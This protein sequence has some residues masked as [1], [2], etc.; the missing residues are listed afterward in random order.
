[1]R[2]ERVRLLLFISLA[3]CHGLLYL[4]V[5][6][7]WQHYDE[8]THYEFSRLIAVLGRMPT[9]KEVDL[10]SRRAIG[11]S[12]IR[13]HFYNPG[14][15][16]PDFT[17][18]QPARLGYSQQVHP[19]FYYTLN[20]WAINLAPAASVE[21]QLYIARLVSVLLY[22]LTILTA[23]RIVTV[24]LPER[25]FFR[26]MLLLLLIFMPAFA[27][28][29]SAM[30]NDVLV[31]FGM[32]VLLLG[33][34]YLV[35][36][37]LRPLPLLLALLAL[38]VAFFAKRTSIVGIVPLAMALFWSLFR[39]PI[40]IR[41]WLSLLIIA[42]VAFGLLAFAPTTIKL[43][44]GLHATLGP[45]PWLAQLDRSYLRLD[46]ARFV[47]SL[48]DIPAGLAVYPNLMYRLFASF[49]M[50]YS[51]GHIR[52]GSGWE[53]AMI[54]VAGSCAAGLLIRGVRTYRQVGM[55]EQRWIWLLLVTALAATI[56]TSLRIHPLPI[57]GG[58][59]YVP[60]GRYIYVA[61]IPVLWL[62]ALGAEALVPRRWAH[63]ALWLLVGVMLCLDIAAWAV[64]IPS[65]YYQSNFP[66]T[67]FAVGKPGLAGWPPIYGLVAIAYLGLVGAVVRQELR[68][69]K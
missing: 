42:G 51:W 35:R 57:Y 53:L 3:C 48:S 19:P 16:I 12:M 33:C 17:G 22:T 45:R 39:R 1:M 55:I 21:T 56:M 38:G 27:D 28:I 18:P 46:L 13:F 60:V 2:S 15:A 52:M 54:G 69:E 36:D 9:L 66:P 37:G 20:A 68:T 44:D 62:M 58:Y 23:W 24:S 10:P 40:P 11:E 59:S 63:Y 6:P 26:S 8:P 34:A 49:W 30:N 50:R 4:L 25:P 64:V 43:A 7:P 41:F 31:N 47:A 32:A 67:A 65:Y 5:L 29:M 14:E 61:I